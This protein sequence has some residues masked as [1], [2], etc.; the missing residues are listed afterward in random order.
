MLYVTSCRKKQQNHPSLWTTN[1][2]FLHAH[3]HQAHKTDFSC[4][5]LKLLH[6]ICTLNKLSW[7]LELFFTNNNRFSHNLNTTNMPFRTR[8][9]QHAERQQSLTENQNLVHQSKLSAAWW[10]K[11]N[12]NLNRTVIIAVTWKNFFTSS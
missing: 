9:K 3:L 1:N 4:K 7:N 8:P 2:P 11:Y 12:N 5:T 6:V 10:K